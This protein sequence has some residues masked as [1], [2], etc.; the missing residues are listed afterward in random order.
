[1]YFE[2]ETILEED[3]KAKTMQNKNESF[4]KVDCA[5]AVLEIEGFI[6][7]KVE[8]LNRRGVVLGLSGG[9]DSTVVAY[10]SARSLGNQKV[11]ALF[12]PERDTSAESKKGCLFS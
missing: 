12:L 3:G 6:K 10:L 11:F 4:L 5:K 1:M 2:E 9:L 7:S 8:A